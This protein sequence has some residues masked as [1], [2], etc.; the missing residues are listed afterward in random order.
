M[1]QSRHGACLVPPARWPPARRFR[2]ANQGVHCRLV[3]VA[4]RLWALLENFDGEVEDH[5]PVVSV[6]LEGGDVIDVFRAERVRERP[7]VWR[8]RGFIGERE[9]PMEIR[10]LLLGTT[11]ERAVAMTEPGSVDASHMAGQIV[12]DVRASTRALGD[13]AEVIAQAIRQRLD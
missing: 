8:I 5:V 11:D 3:L 13:L 7:I 4:Q 9:E 10:A 6:R 1:P 2:I 12:T